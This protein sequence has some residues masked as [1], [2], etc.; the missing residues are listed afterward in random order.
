MHV[1]KLCLYITGSELDRKLKEKP[2]RLVVL[3]V[4]TP[5]EFADRHIKAAV[6]IPLDEL[7][8]NINTLDKHS[9][10]VVVCKSGKRAKQ[11]A[12]TL[13]EAGF[14]P[15]VLEKGL[16]GWLELGLKA[17]QS[18]EHLSIERQTQLA[19]GLGILTGLLFALCVSKWFLIL[20][21]I[22]G[23]GLTYAG[24][25]GNCGLAMLLTKAPWNQRCKSVSVGPNCNSVDRSCM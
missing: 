16:T 15:K 3:D 1:P 14:E 10:L 24:L 17:E 4:R 5:A 25:S 20:P 2:E 19:I 18:T 13:M 23:T 21:A 11:A 6:N 22:F 8:G 7:S 9:E 12:G